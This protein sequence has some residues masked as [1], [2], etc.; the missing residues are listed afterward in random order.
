MHSRHLR[1]HEKKTKSND[2]VKDSAHIAKYVDDLSMYRGTAIR[3]CRPGM[4][5]SNESL[6]ERLY[7]GGKSI[8]QTWNGRHIRK[9]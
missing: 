1:P 3:L 8:M 2:D 4:D 6:L 7:K 5:A 9:S